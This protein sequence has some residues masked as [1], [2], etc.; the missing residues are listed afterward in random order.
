MAYSAAECI[1][2]YERIKDNQP[3]IPLARKAL[4]SN[5]SV[6]RKSP[7]RRGALSTKQYSARYVTADCFA[8]LAMMQSNLLVPCATLRYKNLLNPGEPYDH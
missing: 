7:R 3:I 8:T 2:K 6:K 5:P 4:G 1:S